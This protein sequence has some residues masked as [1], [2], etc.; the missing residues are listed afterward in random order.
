L[1]TQARKGGG[2]HRSPSLFSYLAARGRASPVC[3]YNGCVVSCASLV[4]A[5]QRPSSLLYYLIVR[6]SL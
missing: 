2:A 4:I 3:G 5:R 6:T 1:S